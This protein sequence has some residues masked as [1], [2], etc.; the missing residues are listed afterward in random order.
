MLYIKIND[1]NDNFINVVLTKFSEI[2][3]YLDDLVADQEYLSKS[4]Q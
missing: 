1:L 3:E 4:L 2:V